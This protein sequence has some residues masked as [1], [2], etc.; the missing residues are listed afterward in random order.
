M[1]KVYEEK[2][3]IFADSDILL[4]ILLKREPFYVSAINMFEA[5][6]SGEL[7]VYAS[8][9]CFT[10]IFYVL[11]RIAG[12]QKTKYAIKLLLDNINIL[13]EDE[14]IVKAALDSDF[15]D[16]EDAMQYYTAKKFNMKFIITRNIKDFKVKDIPVMTADDFL[17]SL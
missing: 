8:A 16:F 15:S 5:A 12:N 2:I 10:N 11:R 3:N 6:K 7:N 1:G 9:V 4:D 14:K 13:S 17:K